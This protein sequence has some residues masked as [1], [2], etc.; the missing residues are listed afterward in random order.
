MNDG[1]ARVNPTWVDISR[2]FQNQL[3]GWP[4]DTPFAFD[5]AWARAAGAS[6]NV[7]RINTSLHTGTHLDAP[8]HFDDQGATIDALPLATFVGPA[9]V[10]DVRGQA[11]IS[12]NALRDVDL[13]ATPRLLLRTDAWPDDARFPDWIPIIEPDVPAY[14]QDQGVVLLGVDL[15]S[16]DPLESKDLRLHHALARAGVMILEGLDL[17]Q[18]DSGVYELIALPLRIVGADGAPTRAIL[19]AI[20]P[21]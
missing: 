4:G 2:K 8:F 18:V 12:R 20:P 3:A 14:L 5:L 15:P 16:V 13:R 10:V 17:S 9:R 6:V 11:T 1:S 21:D 19:R 7:G